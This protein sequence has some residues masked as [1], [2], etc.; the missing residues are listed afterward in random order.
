MKE[1]DSDERLLEI[2]GN[3]AVRDIV[4]FVAMGEPPNGDILRKEALDEIPAQV[5]SYLSLSR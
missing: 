3:K 1:L 5:S 4:Q 2:N